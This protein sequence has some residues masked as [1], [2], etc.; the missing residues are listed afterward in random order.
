MEFPG[1]LS[2]SLWHLLAYM[3]RPAAGP[4]FLLYRY[5][6]DLE[7]I[8]LR[9]AN[10]PTM[11]H[12]TPFTVSGRGLSLREPGSVRPITTAYSEQA[13]AWGL[14]RFGAMFAR[15]VGAKGR[16]L[17]TFDYNEFGFLNERVIGHQGLIGA[18]GSVRG[19]DLE[20]LILSANRDSLSWL[21]AR[22]GL[23]LGPASVRAW[24]TTF[25][26]YGSG[27]ATAG[28]RVAGL[29]LCLSREELSWEGQFMGL[30]APRVAWSQGSFGAWVGWL[31]ADSGTGPTVG[32]RVSGSRG[33]LEAGYRTEIPDPAFMPGLREPI[34]EAYI[35]GEA[36]G[37][38]ITARTDA[39]WGHWLYGYMGDSGGTVGLA[40]GARTTS[41]LVSKWNLGPLIAGLSGQAAWFSVQA[42]ERF[43]WQGG[44][45]LGLRLSLLEGDLAIVPS[46]SGHYYDEP[47]AGFWSAARLDLTFYRSVVAYVSLENLAD[48]TLRFF[49]SKWDKR[50]WRFGASLVLW[51]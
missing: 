3:A 28:L 33:A 48:D 41:G 30:W 38:G 45:L 5:P 23:G 15:G 8:T 27:G 11:F 43:Y 40:R 19:L 36:K 22:A 51:D 26:P 37:F 1:L 50:A 10:D 12:S 39:G 18:D 6:F 25:G 24:R 31:F 29:G 16:V 21:H 49:G 42:P 14:S 4:G 44:G 9:F 13:G 35:S 34:S 17:G 20:G 47:F 2:D 46:L 7:G 32:A